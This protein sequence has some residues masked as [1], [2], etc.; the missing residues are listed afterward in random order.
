MEKDNWARVVVPL[1]IALVVFYVTFVVLQWTLIVAA[2]LSLGCYAGLIFLFIPVLRISGISVEHIK[3]RDE[4]ITLLEEGEKDLS[5]IKTIM[6][7]S[8]DPE[9]KF[10]A[11]NVYREGENIIEYIKKNPAKAIM[12]RRFFNY[13]LDKTDEILKKYHD[14]RS[15]GIET[16]HLRSLK[17][18][19]LSALEAISRGMVLQFS[20]LISSEVID[21]EADIKLLESTIRMEDS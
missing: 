10:K 1:L 12:A 6:E 21:I 5:S 7:K 2:S 8:K 19:T 18:K 11:Q 9:I 16:D 13:Y 4:I 17:G 14:L 15:A 20:K 3:N